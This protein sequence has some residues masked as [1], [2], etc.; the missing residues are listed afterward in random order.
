M[1][2]ARE[3]LLVSRMLSG[4]KDVHLHRTLWSTRGT[5]AYAAV[6]IFTTLWYMYDWRNLDINR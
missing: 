2:S 6:V 4:V 5:M 1:N 3:C